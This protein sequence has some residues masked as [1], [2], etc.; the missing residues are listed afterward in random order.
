MRLGVKVVLITGLIVTLI[1]TTLFVIF[2]TRIESQID[3]QILTKARSIYK[4]VV[5]TRHWLADH[6]GVLVRKMPGMKPNLFLQHPE[7]ITNDGDTLLLRNPA[8]V[9]RELSELSQSMGGD[10]SYHLAS[11]NYINTQNKPDVFESAALLFFE[12]ST[13]REK[14][15]EY[16]RVENKEGEKYFRYFAPLYTEESCLNCHAEQG[17]KLGDLRGGISVI[18]NIESILKAQRGNIIIFVMLAIFSVTILVILIFIS[19]Q[20]SIIKPLRIIEDSAQKIEDGNYNIKLNIKSKDEIGHLAKAFQ[21]M[22]E[23]IERDTE[24]LKNSESKYRSLIENSLESIAVIDSH[25]KIIESNSKMTALTQYSNTNLKQ[26]NFFELIDKKEKQSLPSESIDVS[27]SNE[28]YE[29]VLFSQNNMR[30]PVEVYSI[31]GFNLGVRSDLSFV[32]VRDLSKRKQVEKYAIQT[33]KMFALGQLSSGIAHEIR[34]PLFALNNNIGFLHRH[35]DE[36]DYFNDIYPDLKDSIN[37]IHR[38]VS[39]ILDYSKPHTPE[40]KEISV[41]QIIEKSLTLI[42]KQLEKSSIKIVKQLDNNLETVMADSHQLEQVCVNLILNAKQ[43]IGSKGTVTI[44][45]A[46]HAKKVHLIIEDT[47]CGIA[48][49]EIDRIFNPFYSTFSDGTGLGLSIVQKI[50]EEHNARYSINS[51]TDYGT[52]FTIRLPMAKGIEK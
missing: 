34:N 33:E 45:T 37:R 20:K 41:N 29:T 7:L 1:I 44:K 24:R 14:A 13:K 18:M 38:I 9:T 36:N 28:H 2:I 43:A 39:T 47:G 19:I 6:D 48:K 40:L 15:K 22:S 32:Y 27:G 50:L 3:E 23:K 30:I 31:K 26:I 25:G 8:M 4:N 11:E 17:Y 42:K 10:F 46:N 21:S 5:I 35:L 49:E 12:D 16:Y 52:T 51:E